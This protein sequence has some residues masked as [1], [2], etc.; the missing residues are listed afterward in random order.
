MVHFWLVFFVDILRNLYFQD[1]MCTS[2]KLENPVQLKIP[3]DI[4]L[5]LHPGQERTIPCLIFCQKF[6]YA[7]LGLTSFNLMSVV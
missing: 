1:S 2:H 5:E 6:A 7:T 4:S 3:E